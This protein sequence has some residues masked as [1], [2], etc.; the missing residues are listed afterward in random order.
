MADDDQQNNQD[1]YQFADLDV[2][3]MEQEAASESEEDESLES[4]D[5]GVSSPPGRGRFDQIDPKVLNIVRKGAIAVAALISVLIVYKGITS[6]FSSK[7][8]TKE[9][10]TATATKTQPAPKTALPINTPKTENVTVSRAPMTGSDNNRSVSMLQKEQKQIEDELSDIRVQISTVTQNISDVSSKMTDVQQTMLVLSERLEQQSQQMG[11]LQ[12][13]RRTRRVTSSADSPSRP[14][15][16]APKPTYSIQA[17]IPGRAWL[18][19]SQGKT[20]T[21]SRGSPVPG[22]GTIRLINAKVGRVFT[23]SG[24]VIQFSQADT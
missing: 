5:E 6:F 9:I 3:G 11:R 13:M 23:S 16:R 8:S 10:I 4:G 14:R 1:E 17:I 2:L 22:Y 19:S 24:R 15:T 12:S 7:S 18:M 20:L 21:V